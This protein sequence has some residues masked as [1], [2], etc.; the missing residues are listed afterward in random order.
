MDYNFHTHTFRCNHAVGREDEYVKIAMDN[1]IKFMGFS[2]H[3]PLV[4]ED[5]KESIYRLP[6]A[7]ACEYVNAVNELKEK[8][9]DSLEL[10]LGFE[11]EY[12]PEY[13][14]TMLKT[15]ISF[16]VEYLILGQHY[17]K[18][19]HK[20]SPHVVIETDNHLEL[21]EHVNAVVEGIKTGV[22]TYVAHPD[23][24]NFVGDDKVYKQE[25]R[26]IAV[27]SKEY[28]VPL[29]INFLGI[30][31]NRNYPDLRFWEVVGEVQS[32]VTFGL[33]S[34]NPKDAYDSKSLLVAKE[35]VK[36]YNLNYI[37]K[38]NLIKIKDI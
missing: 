18:P 16:G 13:F 29:E 27:A 20:G 33:D 26:K 7:F 1:G 12:Y 14:H 28:N 23:I 9:K 3:I 31:R 6:Y 36:N 4:R 22:F 15:A 30:R 35:M 8:F 5:G 19:E 34:H 17:T 2:E 32:P 11:M 21:V 25:M 10:H 24:F 38:P 37:G